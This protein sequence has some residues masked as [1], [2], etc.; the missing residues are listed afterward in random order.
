MLCDTL[1][2]TRLSL[3]QVLH[4]KVDGFGLILEIPFI[5]KIMTSTQ[6]NTL[7]IISMFNIRASIESIFERANLLSSAYRQSTHL[8][9]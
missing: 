1:L 3:T 2:G 8:G 9:V 6:I 5:Y 7:I 4:T